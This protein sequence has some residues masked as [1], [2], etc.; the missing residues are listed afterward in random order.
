MLTFKNL[1]ELV[2][3]R[4][5]E[6]I[7]IEKVGNLYALQLKLLKNIGDWFWH[8]SFMRINGVSNEPFDSLNTAFSSGDNKDSVELNQNLIL[9]SLK[10]DKKIVQ[11]PELCHT[12]NVKV[13]SKNKNASKITIE[14]T[15]AVVFLDNSQCL[16]MSTADCNPIF[17]ID[18]KQKYIGLIHAGW[19]GLVNNII[20][21]TID[22]MVLNGSKP[23]DIYVGVGPS[24]GPC[25]Y[26]LKDPAQ[27]DMPEWRPYLSHD[28]K[29]LTA[30]DL[31]RP[32]E[33][34]LIQTGIPKGNIQMSEF[35]TACNNDLFF[36]FWTG[37][38][39]TGRFASV[40]YKK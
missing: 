35:C 13:V 29:G 18:S 26:K 32:V 37:K 25:C 4:L 10:I 20:K 23:D 12:S 33:D 30:I 1:S 3:N 39:N 8:G 21:K 24:I 5:P 11:I 2:D 31:W 34:Q 36:S 19:K 22:V 9:N 17:L 14:N 28:D 27:N 15:D 16:F 38:P 6:N 7:S 40:I